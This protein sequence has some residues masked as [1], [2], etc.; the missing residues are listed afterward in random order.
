MTKKLF[1]TDGIRGTANHYPMTPEMALAVGKAVARV[2]KKKNGKIHQIV[3]GK[4]TRL[5]GYM[6]E[7]ALTSGIVSQG[8]NVLLVGPLP[9]P[10][11]A[12]LIKS[13][14]ADAGIVISASHNPAKD[15]GIKI[16]DSNGLKLSDSLEKEI[17][18]DIF[19]DENEEN[20]TKI[21][22]A[23]RVND[24]KGRYIE[25][26][27]STINNLSL[28]DL[29]IVLDCANGASYNTAPIILN[30]LNSELTV[31][32]ITP[33]GHNINLNCGA[34]FPK[35]IQEEVKKLNADIGIAL[36]G[37][38]DRIIVCDESGEIVDGDQI[39]AICAIELKKEKKLK[40]NAVVST[41]MSNL[42]F[43][44]AMQKAGINVEITK[45]GDRFVIER[46]IEKGINFGGEQS[47]HI[48]FLDYSTTGDGI[49]TALQLLKI[50][51]KTGKKLSELSSGMEK[52]PQVL[53]NVKVKEKKAIEELK[54]VNQKIKEIENTLL[55]QGRVLVRYSG[56][57]SICRVMIEGKNQN[58]I[59]D[60]AKIIAQEVKKEIG[61]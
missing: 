17:E 31:L 4:D 50:M 51:K 57:E 35:V 12:K 23:F 16:F 20:D 2:F 44:H 47:G 10:A 34:L 29:K 14:N 24:S 36:D 38:A 18:K 60:F 58:E 49:I 21:G 37:D 13:F 8:V 53:I 55:D 41:V 54:G 15:N 27:K 32:N 33:D 5:S 45:V 61:G 19:S 1:G 59:E 30:E 26:A 11:I 28:S 22:K 42:G 6:L 56:T 39:M 9:T 3:I 25:F 7:T 46:M 48:I 52:L 40:N 43:R